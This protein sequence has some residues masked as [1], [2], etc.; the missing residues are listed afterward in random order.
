[1]GAEPFCVRR[2][3]DGAPLGAVFKANIM[4]PDQVRG[5]YERKETSGSV[6]TTE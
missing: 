5:A 2:D 1:M 6:L 4:S 3:A